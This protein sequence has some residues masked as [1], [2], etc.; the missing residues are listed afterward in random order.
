MEK[1]Y[2]IMKNITI[3]ELEVMLEALRKHREKKRQKKMETQGKTTKANDN[4]EQIQT[5]DKEL[6]TLKAGI[7]VQTRRRPLL[8]DGCCQDFKLFLSVDYDLP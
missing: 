1:I 4:K 3:E 2:A 6:L 7:L 8:Q 5:Q